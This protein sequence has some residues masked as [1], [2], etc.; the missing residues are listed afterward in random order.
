MKKKKNLKSG[1][2]TYFKTNSHQETA[3]QPWGQSPDSPSRETHNIFEIFC[4]T[5]APTK[6][7]MLT[8]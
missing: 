1:S 6:F 5:K 4:R 7:K 2:S 3:V 8:T